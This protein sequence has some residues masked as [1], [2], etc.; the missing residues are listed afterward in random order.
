VI[1]GLSHIIFST[2][3]IEKRI[4][5][6][7]SKGYELKFLKKKIKNNKEKFYFMFHKNKYHDIY[8]LQKKGKYN[9]EFISY[10]DT[11]KGSDRLT[12]SKN[13]INL[14]IPYPKLEKIMFKKFLLIKDNLIIKNDA[15]SKSL[16]FLIRIKKKII[17]GTN[18]LDREGMNTIAFF[19]KDISSL[20]N[21]FIKIKLKC[22]KIFSV[23]LFNNNYKIFIV[24]SKNKIFYEF[25]EIV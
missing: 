17:I 12:L 6:L 4:N 11:L 1:I 21:F 20:R 5:N 3:D 9:I 19:C 16:N 24:K 2:N 7:K 22:T 23:S 15:I 14:H 25:L 18:Y 8:F 13:I 10:F